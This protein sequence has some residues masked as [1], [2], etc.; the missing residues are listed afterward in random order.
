MFVHLTIH[1]PRTGKEQLVI[2]SMHRF[3]EAMTG[4]PG[5]Q[6]VYELRDQK[7]GALIALS[8]WDGEEDWRAARPTMLEAVKGDNLDE[9]E[10]RPP[11]VY[12]LEVV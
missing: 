7:T 10:E 9:W 6:Q 5:L 3:G 12:H 11:E 8:I 1:R 4:L 2:D